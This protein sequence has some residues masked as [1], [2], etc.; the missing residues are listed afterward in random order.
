MISFSPYPL[1]AT[2]SSKS[3]FKGHV[4]TQVAA[5]KKKSTREEEGELAAVYLKHILDR[6]SLVITQEIP[7][8]PADRNAY[9]HFLHP[10]G[11]VA[12]APIG[13]AQSA[14]NQPATWKFTTDTVATAR[15]IYADIGSMPIVGG[16]V[17][18]APETPFFAAR[19]LFVEYA[20]QLLHRFGEVEYWQA[21]GA[22]AAVVLGCLI[23]WLIGWPLLILCSALLGVRGQ[24][25]RPLIA[26]PLRIALMMLAWKLAMPLLGL[27]HGVRRFTDPGSAVL[28]ALAAAWTCWYLVDAIGH[29][30]SG[31][32][33]TRP[34][35]FDD[36]SVSLAI[37]G[38]R[39]AV[40]VVGFLYAADALSIPY[41]GIIAGLGISGLAV[42]FA[43]KETLS[44]VFGA[45][46]LMID[47]PFRRGDSII[48][49][50]TRGVVEHVGIRST[51]IRTPEDSVIVV[52]N[53]RLSDATINNL[54]T[55]RHRL[56][57]ATLVLPYS[58]SGAKVGAF[59]TALEAMLAAH[60]KVVTERV[61]VGVNALTE[62]GYELVATFYLDVGSATDET[63]T[64]HALM[65]DIS[66]LG[67]RMGVLGTTQPEPVA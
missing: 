11:R 1:K 57:K 7:D 60:D 4:E 6:V 22:V 39:I 40:V 19:H 18:R 15:D 63:E 67:E 12:I 20:P 24:E 52:P 23:A 13:N 34:G 3:L 44:N 17:V 50:D 48:A 8:D 45:G 38:L 25:V 53:G 58:V 10:A 41:S 55:R 56:V 30:V 14:S 36:V 32:A 46:I 26:W 33:T 61:S 35:S 5:S 27:P 51:R 54:G 65:L 29:R 62:A 31:H 66:A 9:V 47:R 16:G 28:L 49:G 59:K 64:R 2:P 21:L 42:A 43:S 37:A